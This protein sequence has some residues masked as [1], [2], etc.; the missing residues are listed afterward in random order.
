MAKMQIAGFKSY[1]VMPVPVFAPVEPDQTRQ[2][3]LAAMND[4][5]DKATTY[6]K[7]SLLDAVNRSLVSSVWYWPNV[8]QR[9]DG[10]E[11]GSPRDIF[12]TGS[13]YVAHKYTSSVS[14]TKGTVMLHVQSPYAAIVHFGGVIQPY[15]NP[16]LPSFIY[17][18][19]PWISAAMLGERGL[20]KPDFEGDI[21]KAIQEA[22]AAV[23]S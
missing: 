8:T 19:R 23:F 5:L 14:K 10:T 20:P 22:W 2:K 6:I 3:T 15:G 16:N 4:G 21:T 7:T 1:F 17:P 11:A 9:K 13:L 18:A 12:D